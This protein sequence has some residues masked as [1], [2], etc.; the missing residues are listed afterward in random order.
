LAPPAL[1]RAEE[2]AVIDFQVPPE[3]L[4]IRDRVRRFVQEDCIPVEPELDHRPLPEVLTPLQARAKEL[5]L[6]APFV[7]REWGGMGLGPLANALV[8]I[9]LGESRLATMAMCS[10]G[11]DDATILTL[12]KFGTEEQKE[13]YVR[14]WLRGE[15]RICFTM[16]E[17]AAG[18][19]A[20]GMRTTAVRDGDHWVIN[21]EKWMISDASN[22]NV[23]LLMA[24]TSSEGPRHRQFS[25]ILVDLPNPGYRILRDIPTMETRNPHHGRFNLGHAEVRIENLTVPATNLLGDEGAGFEMGQHR[26]GYGRLRHG[27]HSVG[28]AQRALDMAAGRAIERETFGQL[29]ADRQGIQ[30]MLAD[31]ATELYIGRLMLLHIAYKMEHGMDLRQENAMAKVFMAGMVHRAVDTAIQIHGS[32]GYTHDTPLASWYT[33]IRAQRLVDGPDEVHRWTVGRNLLKEYRQRGTTAGMAGGD[34]F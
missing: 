28:M 20:T 1:T 32:L 11:P 27:M 15:T 29:L 13:R 18:A 16:T 21:G 12:L 6:W 14:P 5:G 25:T 34:L 31:C 17:R 7:P 9:E 4:A 24:R 19:D 10:Q 22:A 26:L 23:T 2:H 33:E 8:Q 30:W 3:Y